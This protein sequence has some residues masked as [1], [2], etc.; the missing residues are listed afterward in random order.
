MG[1]TAGCSGTQ[2]HPLPPLPVTGRFSAWPMPLQ[3]VVP[4]AN[5]FS[6][7]V[8]L[9]AFPSFTYHNQDKRKGK[10][11]PWQAQVAGTLFYGKNKERKRGNEEGR[12]GTPLP[13]NGFI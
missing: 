8:R 13:E 6:Q 2:C 3:D 5:D 11:I 12:L 10:G 1:R 9:V 4:S 7:R